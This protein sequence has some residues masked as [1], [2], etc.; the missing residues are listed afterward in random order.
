MQYLVMY[1]KTGTGVC[2]H[3]PDLPGVAVAGA[4]E[5]E[6]RDLMRTAIKLHI[7][8]LVEDGEPVPQPSKSEYLEVA[9]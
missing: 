7:E 8:G 9:A 3:V 1:A 6:A 2:A 4:S 5:D